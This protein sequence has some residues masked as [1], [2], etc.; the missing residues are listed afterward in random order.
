MASSSP[1]RPKGSVYQEILFLSDEK[2]KE[3][4]GEKI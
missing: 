4:M 2:E 1:S 3:G